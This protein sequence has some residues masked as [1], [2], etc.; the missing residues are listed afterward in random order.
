[1]DQYHCE[2]LRDN[3]FVCTAYQPDYKNDNESDG[4]PRF[5][6]VDFTIQAGLIDVSLTSAVAWDQ[7]MLKNA[8]TL[9]A[10]GVAATA[11]LAF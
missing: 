5:G 2:A 6:T 9:A 10:V 4:Y 1:M 11:M 3:E 8:V 7:I